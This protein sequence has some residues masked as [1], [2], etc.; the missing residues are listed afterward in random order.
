MRRWRHWYR[1]C[2]KIKEI[3][4]KFW[5]VALCDYLLIVLYWKHTNCTNHYTV[6][7]VLVQVSY[8]DL[9]Q[10]NERKVAAPARNVFT[11]IRRESS[12]MVNLRE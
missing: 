7:T 1:Q 10:R 11:Q 5:M 8:S 6:Y 4:V 9:E 2:E 3:S 12:A